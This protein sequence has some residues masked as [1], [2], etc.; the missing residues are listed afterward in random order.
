LKKFGDKLC[1]KK[2][3]INNVNQSVDSI[4]RH[5]VNK[6]KPNKAKQN[7]EE[8]DNNKENSGDRHFK[9]HIIASVR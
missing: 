4:N 3:Y 7:N 6:T 8:S 2:I 1:V 5:N 9:M